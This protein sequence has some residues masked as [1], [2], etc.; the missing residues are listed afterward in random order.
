MHPGWIA[1]FAALIIILAVAIIAI[2][3]KKRRNSK[4]QDLRT[5]MP[6]RETKSKT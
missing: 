2:T 6:L 3:L 5:Q 4:E 1:L